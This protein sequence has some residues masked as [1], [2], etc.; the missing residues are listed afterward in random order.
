[1]NFSESL[2]L[3][4][5]ITPEKSKG[6]GKTVKKSKTLSNQSTPSWMLEEHKED[7]RD[8][9]EIAVM[10]QQVCEVEEYS[11]SRTTRR[12]R[13]P[14]SAEEDPN[15]VAMK[16]WMQTGNLLADVNKELAEI[17]HNLATLVWVKD[18]MEENKKKM[19]KKS[20]YDGRAEKM[21]KQRYLEELYPAGVEQV[22]TKKSEL[23]ARRKDLLGRQKKIGKER[24]RLENKL[25]PSE[26]K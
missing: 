1:M 16:C 25:F 23:K 13:G 4:M 11:P 22:A 7:P 14:E 20:K 8:L 2:E 19:K 5:P 3:S 9:D 21:L 26:K 10:L 17:E 15:F 18:K 6:K 24:E 12:R